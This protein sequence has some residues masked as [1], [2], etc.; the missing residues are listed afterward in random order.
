MTPHHDDHDEHGHPH[1]EGPVKRDEARA[2]VKEW[3][4]KPE[5]KQNGPNDE[6][7]ERTRNDTLTSTD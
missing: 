2:R 5:H 6:R 7:N 1:G 4:D 3:F